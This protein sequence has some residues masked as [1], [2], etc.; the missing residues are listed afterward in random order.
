[1]DNS[2]VKKLG[3]DLYEDMVSRNTLAPFTEQYPDI[4]L[5]QAYEIQLQYMYMLLS[6][7]CLKT[8]PYYIRDHI[9]L[10]ILFRIFQLHLHF[11]L[12]LFLPR[13]YYLLLSLQNQY[14]K[15]RLL[16]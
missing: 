8:I 3:N 5:E 13:Y 7:D 1:M 15:M 4:T 10:K 2:Q 11:E 9:Y 14:E 16:Y 12:L 6:T